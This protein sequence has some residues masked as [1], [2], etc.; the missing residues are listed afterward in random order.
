MRSATIC[1]VYNRPP[2][3]LTAN[4]N[5]EDSVMYSFEVDMWSFGCCLLE[6][7]TGCVPFPG[8]TPDTVYHL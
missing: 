4:D 1:T 7:E 6:M 8:D 5:D 3:L 2:K